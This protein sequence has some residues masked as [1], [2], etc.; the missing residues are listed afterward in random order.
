MKVD[1]EDE[2][3]PTYGDLLKEGKFPVEIKDEEA[4]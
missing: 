4:E 2:K 1:P 3:S